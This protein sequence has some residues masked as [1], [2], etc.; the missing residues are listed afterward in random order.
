LREGGLISYE[1]RPS[2]FF[3]PDG[4]ADLCELIATPTQQRLEGELFDTSRHYFFF[5]TL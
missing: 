4:V 1:A 3:Q 5:I 2:G